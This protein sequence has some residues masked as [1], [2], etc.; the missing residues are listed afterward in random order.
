M[1]KLDI[2][3]IFF[4]LNGEGLLIGVPTVFVRL[5][6]C[7]LRCQWCDTAYAW[8]TGTEKG[9]PD[10]VKEVKRAD[11]GFCIWV[12]IT[13]GEPLIQ[14]IDGLTKNLKK[15]GYRI[16]IETNGS[17]YKKALNTCDF[18]SADLKT[19]SSRNPTTD[20]QTF[21]KICTAIKKRSGQVKAVIA[22]KNDY[23]FVYE[24]VQEHNLKVPLVLQP[25][26]GTLTYK[27]LCELYFEDPVP[28][29]HIMVLTQIHKIGDIK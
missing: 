2:S 27:N 6:G 5:S 13:G 3:E 18:I 24:F 16:G 19:P 1:N 7:N 22:D 10:I 20:V 17:L 26:W 9:I 12:L 4:S 11:N 29:R 25:C 28:T 23:Q 8:N 14:N 21:K 15:A